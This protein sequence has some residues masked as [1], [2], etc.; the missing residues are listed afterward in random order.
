MTRYAM[1]RD[2]AVEPDACGS[3]ARDAVE[4]P[5][6]ATGP[7]PRMSVCG[8]PFRLDDSDDTGGVR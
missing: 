1:E 4:A 5:V 6:E 7:S 3:N 8:R 2:E